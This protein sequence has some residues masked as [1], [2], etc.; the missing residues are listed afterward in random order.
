LEYLAEKTRQQQQQHQPTATIATSQVTNKDEL[1]SMAVSLES[2]DI[3]NKEKEDAHRNA[4]GNDDLTNINDNMTQPTITVSTSTNHSKYDF[5]PQYSVDVQVVNRSKS[6]RKPSKTVSIEVLPFIQ[7]STTHNDHTT[8]NTTTINNTTQESEQCT[9]STQPKEKST[10][11][12]ES[13]TVSSNVNMQDNHKSLHPRAYHRGIEGEEPRNKTTGQL[14]KDVGMTDTNYAWDILPRDCIIPIRIQFPL[15]EP[16]SDHDMSEEQNSISVVKQR[17]NERRSKSAML[18]TESQRQAQR[19]S[20]DANLVI[21]DDTIQWDLSNPNT[22]TP[23]VYATNLGAEFGL[24]FLRILDLARSIQSQIDEF[25]R[26]YVIY[27][28]PISA[29]DPYEQQR[30]K[31]GLQPLKYKYETKMHGGHCATNV[32]TQFKLFDDVQ[33][34]THTLEDLNQDSNTAVESQMSNRKKKDDKVIRPNKY[35]YDV[36]PIDQIPTHDIGSYDVDPTYS[37]EFFRRAKEE[38][39]KMIKILAGKATECSDGK[40][41]FCRRSRKC[42]IQFPCGIESHVY[43]DFHTSVSSRIECV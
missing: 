21:F 11:T 26:D 2:G 3:V 5:G 34:C 31:S 43:C 32:A 8:T 13:H 39:I 35:S 33:R 41:H 36:T 28:V 1:H 24:S 25:V 29:L 37:K 10:E 20:K 42:S 14:Y 7:L 27:H 17:R 15:S 6:K 16:D 38:N 30:S 22:P 40:C 18:L 12:K 4:Q 9:T 23:I 19:E